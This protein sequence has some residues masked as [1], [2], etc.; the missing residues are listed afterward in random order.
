MGQFAQFFPRSHEFNQILGDEPTHEELLEG[1]G[2]KPSSSEDRLVALD[3]TKAGRKL[4]NSAEAE[5]VH[6]LGK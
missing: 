1:H 6:S 2:G 5:M 4:T 3:L